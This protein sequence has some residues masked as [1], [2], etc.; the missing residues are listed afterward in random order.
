M[1]GQKLPVTIGIVPPR[2]MSSSDTLAIDVGVFLDLSFRQ[3][4]VELIICLRELHAFQPEEIHQTRV[5]IRTLQSYLY[6]FDDLLKSKH[7][8]GFSTWLREIQQSLTLI[9]NLDVFSELI[10]TDKV[11]VVNRQMVVEEITRQRALELSNLS[12]RLTPELVMEYV[13]TVEVFANNLPIKLKFLNMKSRAQYKSLIADVKEVWTTFQ[14]IFESNQ[15]KSTPRSRHQLRISAK[16]VRYIYELSQR[17]GLSEHP[18]RLLR[19][20][21]LQDRLG[22]EN[23]L[24]NFAKWLRI[25]FPEK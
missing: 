4:C 21:E 16:N 3:P 15:I 8:R 19:V 12:P 23:D 14:A 10:S 9:R 18:K 20:T 6:A 5:A 22:T 24:Y 2:L 7:V 1:H 13:H 25:N 17:M 11:E